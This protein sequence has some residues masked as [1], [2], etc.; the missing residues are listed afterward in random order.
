MGQVS[1]KMRRATA[2]YG[3]FCPACEEMHPLPD[4][5]D[6]DGNVDK[7]TF[8]PSFRHGS[9]QTIKIDGRWTGEW[10]RDAAGKPV[11]RVCHYIITKGIVQYCGDCTHALAGQS[12]EM[13]DLP[14][15]ARDDNGG[16]A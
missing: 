12:V 11:K 6:F 4:A 7:P 2:G 1:A 10:V 3:W 15:W 14:A 13:P 5:W 9:M 16:G 8:S